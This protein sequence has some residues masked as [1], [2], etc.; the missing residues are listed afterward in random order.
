MLDNTGVTGSYTSSEG[1]TGDAV[2]GTSAKCAA[3]VSFSYL[4]AY[5]LAPTGTISAR[6]DWNG[7]LR[8]TSRTSVW[9][10]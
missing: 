6:R 10:P 9:N 7:R 8:I 3:T 1:K 4:R 5:L 2:W